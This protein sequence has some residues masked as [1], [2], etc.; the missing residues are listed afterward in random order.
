MLLYAVMEFDNE[1][2][3]ATVQSGNI[4]ITQSLQ[5]KKIVVLLIQ[6][7]WLFVLSYCF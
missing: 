2:V 3:R 5:I 1:K 4:Y 7:L 6:K